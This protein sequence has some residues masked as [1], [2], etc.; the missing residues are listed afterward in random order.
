MYKLFF[1]VPKSHLASVKDAL[2]E[3]GA[4]QLGGY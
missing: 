1:V 2:F 4:G 3:Q